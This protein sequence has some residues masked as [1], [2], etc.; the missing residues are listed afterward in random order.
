[1]N[2]LYIF[3]KSPWARR[4]MED[5][6]PRLDPQD[7]VLLIQDA[8]LAL[9]GAPAGVRETLQGLQG[10]LFALEADLVARGIAA[11]ETRIVDDK[12]AVDLLARHD[13]VLAL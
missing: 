2:T 11:G 12:V 10:R 3:T 4:D 1:M 6:L 5:W 9:K 8:V 13:R 7:G